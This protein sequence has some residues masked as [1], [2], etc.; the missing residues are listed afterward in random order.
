MAH[1]FMST[2]EGDENLDRLVVGRFFNDC[3]HCDGI[4]CL[5]D[6]LR[7]LFDGEGLRASGGRVRAG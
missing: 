6:G 2:Y 7:L 5:V 3:T 1:N 4:V